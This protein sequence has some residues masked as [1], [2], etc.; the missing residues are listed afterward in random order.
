MS[1]CETCGGFIRFVGEH[2]DPKPC[3]EC[4]LTIPLLVK[5]PSPLYRAASAM[6]ERYVRLVESGDA[7]NW[8]AETEEEV[9]EL[10]KAL[11]ET[12]P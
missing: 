1:L 3:P 5:E 4:G 8:D 10:R 2:N 12:K 9:I 6:L 11:N 7:G